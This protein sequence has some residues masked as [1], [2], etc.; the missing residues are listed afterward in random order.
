MSRAPHARA[1]RPAPGPPTQRSRSGQKVQIADAQTTSPLA[2]GNHLMRHIDRAP[3]A[4]TVRRTSSKSQSQPRADLTRQK[5]KRNFFEDAFAV[6]PTS[7]ARERVHGDAMV[8]AEVKT[9]IRDE[10]TFI[11]ELSYHLSTRYQRPV[12]SIA[13]TLHH[14]ACMFWG[15][16]FDPA[17]VMAVSALPAQL[18][19]TTNKRNAAL[20]QRHMEETLG[21][22]PARGLLRFVPVREE[23]LA[24]NGRTMA[25]EID[26]LERGGSALD[27]QQQQQDGD[28]GGELTTVGEDSLAALRPPLS[29]NLPTPELTPPDSGDEGLPSMPG[30]YPQTAPE[31][32]PES[33]H[34]PQRKAAQRKKSFVA[35][36]FGRSGGKSS[37]RSSLPTVE[38]EQ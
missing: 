32:E 11:T 33:P 22:A 2:E 14:G 24:C 6:N 15:G 21:V 26:E 10:Y 5:S 31:I 7:S 23:H 8:L 12:S 17:Y 37:G 29:T 1:S 38:D 20:I 27:H 36:I 13:V 18:Q 35:T 4:D 3:L 28:G 34:S 19:P 25:G 16:S 9:N 30:S